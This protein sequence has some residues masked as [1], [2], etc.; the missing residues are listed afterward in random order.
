M[1][2]RNTA[3]NH[4][5]EPSEKHIGEIMNDEYIAEIFA[6]ADS[7]PTEEN[8]QKAEIY[9]ALGIAAARKKGLRDLRPN[10]QPEAREPGIREY[11]WDSIQETTF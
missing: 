3:E 5:K 10:L 1:I 4:E 9:K 11:V 6:L 8:I 2:A 7:N